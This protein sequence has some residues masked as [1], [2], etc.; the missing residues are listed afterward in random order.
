MDEGSQPAKSGPSSDPWN[1]ICSDLNPNDLSFFQ[2]SDIFN[3]NDLALK[4]DNLTD[5]FTQPV[6]TTPGSSAQ[7]Q[8]ALKWMFDK[9]NGLESSL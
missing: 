9:G 5:I 1:S 3:D 7:F 4:A 6:E 2:N 8:D